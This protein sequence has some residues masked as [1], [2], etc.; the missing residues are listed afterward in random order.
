[1]PSFHTNLEG[2]L[3]VPIRR[4]HLGGL[5]TPGPFI[6]AHH[7]HLG[8]VSS[9]PRVPIA[10]LDNNNSSVRYYYLKFELI[11]SH[12]FSR[13]SRLLPR[14]RRPAVPVDS[15]RMLDAT[16]GR[17]MPPPSGLDIL[18]KSGG[19]LDLSPAYLHSAP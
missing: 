17:P 3:V 1:M 18:V 8:P 6:V 14:Y 10:Q 13:S 11:I 7:H 4:T 19:P 15:L 2:S 12:Q 5:F 9:L 16:F